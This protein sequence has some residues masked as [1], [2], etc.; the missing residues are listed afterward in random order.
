ME[1]WSPLAKGTVLENATIQQI[2]KR[3][4]VTPAQVGI[5]WSLQHGIVTIP[6]STKIPR[7]EQNFDVFK[8]E[9][10]AEDMRLID[11]LHADMRVSWDP[12]KTLSSV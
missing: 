9:L 6:K 2:A 5:R 10:S 7:L 8:F 4:G 11:G 1:G 12:T 3:H